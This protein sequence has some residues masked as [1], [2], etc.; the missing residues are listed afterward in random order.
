LLQP[1]KHQQRYTGYNHDLK[2]VNASSD[3]NTGIQDHLQKR[4]KRE[5]RVCSLRETT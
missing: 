1:I 5:K 4:E 2:R 3:R